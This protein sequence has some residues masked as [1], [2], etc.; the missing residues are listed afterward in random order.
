M[1]R[2]HRVL[3]G[4]DV[5][6]GLDIPMNLH[7]VQVEFELRQKL[8]LLRQ[9]TLLAFKEEQLWDLLLQSARSFVTLFRHALIA[10]GQQ[11]PENKQEVVQQLSKTIGFDPAAIEQVL[12]VRAHQARRGKATVYALM[13][14]YLAAIEQVTTAVDKA[15][16]PGQK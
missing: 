2:H 8:I 6:Q 16:D 10:M 5:L 9:R 3:F 12:A 4:E 7:R 14:E 1:K 11:A 13:G 15:L